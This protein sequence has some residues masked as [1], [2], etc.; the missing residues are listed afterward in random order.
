MGYRRTFT[1]EIP[2]HYSGSVSY[3]A[4]QSGGS[5]SYSG[6]TYETVH[7]SVYVDTD[8]VD[9]SVADCNHTVDR[10]TGSVA[11]TEAAE[12]VSIR[13][14]AEQIGSTIISGFF[15]TIRSDISQQINELANVVESRVLHLQQ[16][17][18]RCLEKQEQM[19]NDYLRISSRYEKI[20]TEL[21]KELENRIYEL[22]KPTFDFKRKCDEH[23]D[24]ASSTDMVATSTVGNKESGILQSQ[25]SVSVTKNRALEAI[26]KAR[27]FLTTHKHTRDTINSCV[28]NDANEGSLFMPVF[29]VEMVS[30][31]NVNDSCIYTQK[32]FS[33]NK[34]ASRILQ[35][36]LVRQ[37]WS[38]KSQQEKEYIRQSFIA[39]VMKEYPQDDNHA[40]R[41]RENI[42]K[43]FN[44]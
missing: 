5:V 9:E 20:F 42:I 40:A 35:Q 25:I 29:F 12:I 31:P 7:V 13:E 33:K 22:D 39:R 16:M 28:V 2:V 24:R 36:S 27:D 30:S 4:S 18:K 38:P 43:L 14:R 17:A 26:G 8:P 15:R 37:K 11:A 44:I 10:L 19:Q 23:H 21:N 34:E 1:K 6:T 41:V 3:P 32:T